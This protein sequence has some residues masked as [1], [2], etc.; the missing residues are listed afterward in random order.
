M[1]RISKSEAATLHGK[2]MRDRPEAY[3]RFVFSRTEAGFHILATRYIEAMALRGR[4]LT[5]FVTEVLAGVDALFLPTTPVA[6]PT[7]AAVDTDEGAEIAEIIG[8]LARLTRPFSYLG[9][10]ALSVPCGPDEAGLPVGFQ[11]VGRPFA[12]AA[13][14]RLAGHYQRAT[15][16]PRTVP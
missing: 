4:L 11:L 9:V 1:L 5:R 16:W 6:V 3:S 15:A 7:I 12:E 8:G 14:L 13:P 10:P 2:W